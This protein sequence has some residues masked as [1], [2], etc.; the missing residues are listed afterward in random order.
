MQSMV[1]VPFIDLARQNATIKD[2]LL[3][4]VS[5]VLDSGQF[6]HGKEVQEFECAFADLC[7]ARFVLGVNS[8]TDALIMALRAL[9]IGKGDEVITVANSY[10]TTASSVAY[11]GAKPVFIDV[12]DDYTMDPVLLKPA[13]TERTKAIIPV[14][15]TGR[16][17][18]MTAICKIAKE[19]H[20]YVV[21]DAAQAAYAE[22]NGKKVGLFGDIGCFS[23]HP[24][25]VLN[26]CGDGGALM[27]NNEK[28]HEKLLLY[29]N[30]GIFNRNYCKVWSPNSRLDTIQAAILLVKMKYVPS[31]IK[32]RQKNAD[33]YRK[34]LSGERHV[35]C[36]VDKVNEKSTYHL[37]VIQADHRDQ[38]KDYLTEQG[39]GTAIHYPIPIHFQEAA[40]ALGYQ[41]GSLPVTERQSQRILS[42]PV[43]P[44]LGEDNIRY[45]AETIKKFYQKK[46]WS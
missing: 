45:V 18:D 6:I 36:P 42:L 25:K 19:H 38:L 24:L 32:A 11:V 23:F 12:K 22:L 20:L 13:I 37:F 26:A 28:I 31:W 5:N 17:A 7:G 29:G 21:E 2:E 1:K 14:H 43:Y 46:E 8:G 30:N 15:L 40:K 41:P 39:I 33:I 44:E 9:E 34:L 27:T 16:P 3:S 35:Q 4:A 10:V